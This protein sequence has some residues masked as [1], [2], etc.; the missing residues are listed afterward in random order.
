M[1]YLGGMP[2]ANPFY[3]QHHVEPAAEASPPPRR[4]SRQIEK[5]EAT[6]RPV[7]TFVHF[8]GVIQD[9]QVYFLNKEVFN[10]VFLYGRIF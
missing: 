1:L 3:Q 8:K 4:A 10:G 5:T 7:E 9:V 2:Q 6:P